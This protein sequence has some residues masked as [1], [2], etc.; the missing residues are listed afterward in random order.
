[1]IK[2]F[3]EKV[4]PTFTN[5]DR[6]IL[7]VENF[8]EVFFD[9]YEFEISGSKY[10]VEKIS[11][12]NGNPVVSVPVLVEGKSIHEYPFILVK[13]NFEV[14]FNEDNKTFNR[15]LITDSNTD[16]LELF[17]PEEE[18]LRDIFIS[19]SKKEEILQ[20]IKNAKKQALSSI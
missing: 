13:G 14:I 5:S 9:V 6:N 7:Q 4:K 3:S 12:Y 10:P 18:D 8:E 1:M 17:L 15:S 11:E 2:L 20:E 16:E 19:E